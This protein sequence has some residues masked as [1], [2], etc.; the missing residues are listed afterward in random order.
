MKGEA[1]TAAAIHPITGE[2]LALVS[3]P[4]FD[5]NIL[6]LG[7]TAE[8]WKKLQ[9]NELN[10]LLNRFAATYAPWFGDETDYRRHRIERRG[11]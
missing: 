3:S 6:T 5:P 8:Q 9:D 10:P 2:T 11:D 4:S 7:A 1:G